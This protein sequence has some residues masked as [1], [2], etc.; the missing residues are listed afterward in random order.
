MGSRTSRARLI[1]EEE[2]TDVAACNLARCTRDTR[3]DLISSSSN[4]SFYVFLSDR[5][6]RDVSDLVS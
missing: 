4:L 6:S 1:A 2:M 5:T 3:L